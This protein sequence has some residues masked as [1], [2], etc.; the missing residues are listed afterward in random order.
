MAKKFVIRPP[1][2]NPAIGTLTITVDDDDAWLLRSYPWSVQA[3]R[4]GYKYPR[5]TGAIKPWS[6]N[7]DNGR[8]L[9]QVLL[10]IS[11]GRVLHKD[12]DNTNYRRSNL[13]VLGD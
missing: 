9:G 5:T 12:G 2:T 8:H 13:E 10:G 11:K 3:A 6:R 7:T 4:G 1:R